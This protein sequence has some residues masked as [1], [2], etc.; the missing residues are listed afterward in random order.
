MKLFCFITETS[1]YFYFIIILFLNCKNSIFF[2]RI[3]QVSNQQINGFFSATMLWKLDYLESSS[4]EGKLG[5]YWIKDTS[6]YRL[7]K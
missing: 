1:F 5:K 2:V 3:K 6:I 7:S 4:Q